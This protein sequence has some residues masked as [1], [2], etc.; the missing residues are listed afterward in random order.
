MRVISGSF[1]G[2]RLTAPKGLTIRPTPDKV[3][4]AIF[5]VLG[6]RIIESSFLD[7]FAGTGAIG[8]EAL[9]R[10][11]KGVVFVDNNIKAINIIKENLQKCEFENSELHVIKADVIEFIKKTDHQFDIIFLDPPYKSD[12][13]ENALLEISKFNILKDDGEIIW[14]HYYKKITNYELQITNLKLKRTNRYG[15]TAL[16]FF[17][18]N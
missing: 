17:C 8:I 4:G 13:G 7:L 2:R 6:D 10:G 9:S 3:K 18:H 14:E 1:K 12:L 5:N 16:S 15:D 11:A